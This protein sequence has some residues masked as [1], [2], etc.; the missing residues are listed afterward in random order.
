MGPCLHTRGATSHTP[1]T[2]WCDTYML[3]IPTKDGARQGAGSKHP[4]DIVQGRDVH[5][6]PKDA[7]TRH[8]RL[9]RQA[10]LPTSL[11]PANGQEAR[12]CTSLC[13]DGM[14]IAGPN[15]S[16]PA[17]CASSMIC[18]QST[19]RRYPAN[20]IDQIMSTTTFSSGGDRASAASCIRFKY[21]ACRGKDKPST[22]RC[23]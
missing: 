15:M 4:H 1:C 13:D 23:S 21:C 5:C 19:G 10:T 18:R 11:Y 8:M 17:A 3:Q 9:L 22:K 12:A 16:K 7:W 2:S 6:Q 20:A 14:S